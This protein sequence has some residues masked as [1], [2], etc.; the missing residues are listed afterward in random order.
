MTEL[1]EMKQRLKIFY[2]KYDVYLKPALKFI[3]GIVCLFYDQR[4]DR[5]YA[6]DYRDRRCLYCWHFCVL[7]FR[8]I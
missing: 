8:S 7:F 2:G 4:T 1:L 5:I 3:T 6:E